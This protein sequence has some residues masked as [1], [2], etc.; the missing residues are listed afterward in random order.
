MSQD[1]KRRLEYWNLLVH[2]VINYIEEKMRGLYYDDT[3]K[4]NIILIHL[5]V[6][7]GIMIQIDRKLMKKGV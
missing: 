4:P 5:E 7:G 1:K 2:I 3:S 6:R